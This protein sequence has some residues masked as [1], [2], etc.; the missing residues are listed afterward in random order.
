M[1]HEARPLPRKAQPDPK[2]RRQP[3]V[4]GV[5]GVNDP[6]IH[7]LNILAAEMLARVDEEIGFNIE[8][9]AKPCA[10]AQA[11]RQRVRTS[12]TDAVSHAFL[13]MQHHR[14]EGLREQHNRNR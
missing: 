1:R 12:L 6:L 2:K 5:P 7:A 8:G 14:A 13:S 4:V 9:R 3:L 11:A 10:D